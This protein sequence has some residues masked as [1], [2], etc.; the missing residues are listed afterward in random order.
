MVE[1]Y[2]CIV[3]R[4][5]GYSSNGRATQVEPCVSVT[6]IVPTNFYCLGK[7]DHDIVYIEYDIK[8]KRIQQAPRKIF[9]YKRADMDGLHD[10]LVR[11]RDSFLST[12]HSHV[13]VNDMWVSFKSE[14]LSAIERFI[15]SKMTKTK[16]SLPWID[17]SIK[18]LV[19][20]R[21][22]LYFRARK[23]SSPDI[24]NHYKRFRAHVQ[25]S[26]R[27]AYWK[28]ITNI[29]SF[30]NDNPDP[31]CPGKNEKAKKF[32]SF[33]KSL[34]KDASGINTL[35]E[36]G[37]LKT[38]TLDKANI[39]NRQFQSAFTRE[40]NDEIPSKGTS[41]FTAMGEITVDP[42]GVIKLLNNLNIHKA[43]GPDGLSA[44]VLKECSSGVAPVLTCVFNGSLARG[45]VT[46]DWRQAGVAPVF[47]R[48]GRCGAAGCRP[49]SL[50][51]VCNKP[52]ER[53]VVGNVDKHLA[54]GGVLADCRRGFR[55]RGSCGARLVQFCRGLVG[56]LDRAV[57]CGRRRTGVIVVDFAGAFGGVPHG[58][59]LCRL[60]F[61]GIRGSTH[62]WIDSW[63]SERSQ[64]VVLD[65]RASDPVPVLSGVPQGSVLGPVLFLIFIND[66]PDN[67]R[68]SVRLFADV[69]VLY[70]NIKS[71]LECQILQ[72]DLNSL[73]KW[74]LDWQMEFNV[75]K[76]HSMRVTR[77]H[78]SRHIEFN[79]TLHQQTLEQV[80]S[81][82]Y[83]GLTITDDLDWR[84]HISEI[85]CKATKTSA[86]FGTGT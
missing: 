21:D 37:I 10:H 39:C 36:N 84:Q 4:I 44:R 74:E 83:L 41:P 49:V 86:Q 68:S 42:K 13:S 70:R 14:V 76:C 46:D 16:Y 28:H 52:L 51:C 79:Y 15:P 78:P 77:L 6:F 11:C 80:Q 30:E 29:F 1:E 75:S 71:P 17:S 23:S 64:K 50:A 38:D 18:R 81:A 54:L 5:H 43:P 63:L 7:A 26:I 85:T 82:K 32:W 62:K 73:A 59:L 47:G 8:A 69:C 34:K 35:R 40:S 31:D 9:L 72:D 24:K 12:D 58:G 22:K 61:C 3:A 65:G 57:G 19:R 45:A 55:G 33:V 2:V 60:G 25:K 66:L 56:G 53:V 67:I 48:G 20:K 27:D